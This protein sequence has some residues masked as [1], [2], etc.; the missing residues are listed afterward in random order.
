M[1]TIDP[2]TRIGDFIQSKI[3]KYE[4][5]I[6]VLI[7]LI[8]LLRIFNIPFTGMIGTLVLM[9]ISVIYFFSAFAIPDNPELTAIDNF[10]YKLTAIAS[11]VVI[12]GILFL[13]QHW[14]NGKMMIT[15]GLIS[16][17]ASLSYIVYQ[18]ISSPE[19]EKFNN[20]ILLRII[21]LS[22]ISAGVLYFG[23]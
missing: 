5:Q 14:P 16:I 2:K 10:I 23:I 7:I 18:K 20:L 21:V 6:L 22:I 3:L 15:I 9:S 17:I 13:I 4:I 11:S 8:L 1:E 12:I 19:E